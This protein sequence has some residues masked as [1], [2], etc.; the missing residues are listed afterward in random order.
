MP[1]EQS[2]IAAVGNNFIFL[3]VVNDEDDQMEDIIQEEDD[4]ETEAEHAE[5]DRHFTDENVRHIKLFTEVQH[6]QIAIQD[7]WTKFSCLPIMS[8]G[9]VPR[10][11]I[12]R[13]FKRKWHNRNTL[14]SSSSSAPSSPAPSIST[15]FGLMTS[16]LDIVNHCERLV[17][18]SKQCICNIYSMCS[19]EF[20]TQPE[21]SKIF[22]GCVED[23]YNVYV[24]LHKYLFKFKEFIPIKEGPSQDAYLKSHYNSIDSLDVNTASWTLH[25]LFLMTASAIQSTYEIV[26][27]KIFI[28]SVFPKAISSVD[29]FMKEHIP[30]YAFNNTM[31][32]SDLF[33]YV[34]E[35]E[36][37][38]EYNASAAP[39]SFSSLPSHFQLC[40]A[41]VPHNNEL[42]QICITFQVEVQ[43]IQQ[44]K[45]HFIS[46][47]T[48]TSTLAYV[49]NLN[50]A[51]DNC[52]SDFDKFV[53][54]LL[55][56]LLIFYAQL[57]RHFIAEIDRCVDTFVLTWES[58]R[59]FLTCTGPESVIFASTLLLYYRQ[60]H[61]SVKCITWALYGLQRA[62]SF[63]TW[64]AYVSRFSF[65]LMEIH[66]S[67]H[68]IWRTHIW[69]CLNQSWKNNCIDDNFSTEMLL[70]LIETNEMNINP[71]FL[72]YYAIAHS[73]GNYGS[74]TVT[75][76]HLIE[77]KFAQ[78]VSSAS[79]RSTVSL[80]N[81]S[82]AIANIM[83]DKYGYM[84]FRLM[85]AGYRKKAELLEDM[86]IQDIFPCQQGYRLIVLADIANTQLRKQ[87]CAKKA[88]ECILL[89][90]QAVE[91]FQRNKQTVECGVALMNLSKVCLYT[92][93]EIGDDDD[94]LDIA[95]ISSRTEWFSTAMDAF[96]A[97][98]QSISN[99]MPFRFHSATI[100]SCVLGAVD[101]KHTACMQIGFLD[102]AKVCR[103]MMAELLQRY[104]ELV[105]VKYVNPTFIH[106]FN[107]VISES[108]TRWAN[109][110]SASA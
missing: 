7:A 57:T 92:F 52:V 29:N 70:S 47:S 55:M 37:N 13:S 101:A 11:N 14:S 61:N 71:S 34:F 76:I 100:L 56:Y 38:Q 62:L 44:H 95:A 91:H 82:L 75:L 28:F 6:Y 10:H 2:Q 73:S 79:K 96:E 59:F 12:D 46:D 26:H 53:F 45:R 33:T 65:A 24:E 30:L 8:S 48:L 94:D 49:T 31:V 106:E 97:A 90:R 35:R 36:P 104:N 81:T 83:D 84:N 64:K 50:P 103:R 41:N 15:S 21:S 58:S 77:N 4:P 1:P 32:L 27:Q 108:T 107:R 43:Q 89:Y 63:N 9:F 87:V 110:G 74:F 5:D 42:L 67:Q 19:D 40:N 109:V 60:K 16:N 78:P 23:L 102:E 105:D 69:E 93:D 39:G 80:L 88:M 68:D 51:S 72:Y 54:F 86:D 3:D 85:E 98:A 66:R 18:H 99:L 17:Q 25:A 20:V 22:F